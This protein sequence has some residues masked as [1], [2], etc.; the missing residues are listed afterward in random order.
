MSVAPTVLMR[1][2]DGIASPSPE[3]IRHVD[4]SRVNNIGPPPLGI[5]EIVFQ[6]HLIPSEIEFPPF[7][8]LMNYCNSMRA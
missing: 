8:E 2:R 3:L 4:P 5:R 7:F 6:R 1:R